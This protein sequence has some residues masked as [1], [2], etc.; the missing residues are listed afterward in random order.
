MSEFTV[1][2]DTPF[3]GCIDNF[4]SPEECEIL[5]NLG[6]TN[7]VT[8][9]IYNEVGGT[10]TDT[11][12]RDSTTTYFGDLENNDSNIEDLI[13]VIY[14][15]VSK[16]IG[17]DKSQFEKFQI[18]SY[19]TNSHFNI[20]YD[21]FIAKEHNPLYTEKVQ[22]LLSKGGGNRI[23]TVVLYL[24]E[25]EEGG[26]TYF[27][28]PQISVK[29]KQ[30]KLLHFKYNYDDPMDNIKSIHASIP[31]V[32]GIKW[33]ITIIVAECPLDQ[34]MPNFKTFSKE[35]KIVTTLND[36]CYELECG[37]EYDRRTLSISLP[38]NDDPRNTLVVG[39]TAGVDS[40]LL[41]YLLGMLNTYQVIPYVIL[42]VAVD[43]HLILPPNENGL[44]ED[45]RVIPLMV[46]LIQSR[47][48]NKGGILD[49]TYGSDIQKPDSDFF[50]VCPNNIPIKKAFFGMLDYFNT[51]ESRFRKHKF[52]CLGMIAS[53]GDECVGNNQD[54]I[55]LGNSVIKTPLTNLKKYHILDALL[56]LDLEDVLKLATATK[57]N[58]HKHTNLTEKCDIVSCME[59][60]WAYSKLTGFEHLGMDY[61]VNKYIYDP[62]H[63]EIEP[64]NRYEDEV[65]KRNKLIKHDK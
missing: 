24:N 45:Y 39:F 14:S 23:S 19:S 61:F 27:P 7:P 28:W 38:A 52:L 26:E 41:L 43:S 48:K 54:S 1:L 18:T 64:I 53:P 63:P 44:G 13:N 37:P 62:N 35:G 30:G 40:T 33:I 60:R 50:H 46:S 56:Q 4:L 22:K 17:I 20:H 10:I 9:Q 3:I 6:K 21:F 2:N 47:L 55:S 11:G 15:R 65:L 12:I 5:I 36:T 16:A 29:P 34:P 49:F 57:P 32:S 59:R 58:L 8:S 25:P 51:R 42:P 31:V